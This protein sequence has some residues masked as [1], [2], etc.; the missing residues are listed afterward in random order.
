[1]VYCRILASILAVD[2]GMLI[3]GVGNVFT[4]V[5]APRVPV[6]HLDGNRSAVDSPGCTFSAA[7]VLLL[8]CST[9]I[10]SIFVGT[11]APW[12]TLLCRRAV[13]DTVQL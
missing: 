1:M 11:S 13:S 12:G 9:T 4:V 7:A 6:L 3:A 5:S 2:T 8:L 10:G